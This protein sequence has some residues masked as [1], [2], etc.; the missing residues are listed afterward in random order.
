MV[1]GPLQTPQQHPP[2]RSAN[3]GLTLGLISF[4]GGKFSGIS[5]LDDV[6]DG[7][8]LWTEMTKVCG[9]LIGGVSRDLKQDT[10]WKIELLDRRGNPVFRIRLVAET[11]N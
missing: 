9:D 10:E 3:A 6:A 1:A 7:D 4:S 2:C 8:A 11:L 5:E